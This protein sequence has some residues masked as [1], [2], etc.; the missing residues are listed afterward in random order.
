MGFAKG[1][2]IFF[3][4]LISINGLIILGVGVFLKV[5]KDVATDD[6]NA[7]AIAF[8]F[9]GGT[10]FAISFLGCC[11]AVKKSK[12]MLYT[13][14]SIL[15]VI[16]ILQTIIA[17]VLLTSKDKII[18]HLKYDVFANATAE[19]RENE[20]VKSI[21]TN[22]KCCGINGTEDWGTVPDSCKYSE[23]GENESVVV[24]T[25]GCGEKIEALV[26]KYSNNAGAGV[27]VTAFM[28]V[29]GALL[30]FY[31]AK[32]IVKVNRKK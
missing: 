21:Q 19:N 9:I 32:K 13:F 10:V 29:I 16:F 3:N 7:Q 11:G 30:A 8:I 1:L 23:P 5:Q 22:L 24:Y 27:M 31:V 14:G 20:V 15:I 28:E 6:W 18:E 12:C 2:L 17:I 26:S 25:D 4:L